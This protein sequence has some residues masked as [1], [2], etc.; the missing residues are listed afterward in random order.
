MLWIDPDYR[1]VFPTDRIIDEMSSIEGEVYRKGEGRVTLRFE[2]NGEHFFLKRHSGI[3]WR[4]IFKDLL[5]GRLPILG[6]INEW[7]ALER[8][9][10][11]NISTLRP[12]AFAQRGANP[13]TRKSFL[14]TRELVNTISLED[15]VREWQKRPDFIRIKRK[16]IRQVARVAR[17]FHNNGMNHRDF[18]ICHL[19]VARAWLDQPQGD[20][21][22]FVIDLHRAQIRAAVP[23]RWLVKDIG[24]L[25]FSVMEAGLTRND[26]FRFVREYT[27]NDLRKVLKQDAGFWREVK[28]RADR[29]YATRPV[30]TEAGGQ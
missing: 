18:Y 7:H 16:I 23:R 22:I 9:Q 29:L 8:L 30:S 12:V 17:R 2:R 1:K 13:A 4:E 28:N 10:I 25:Y 24:S 15:V 20:P 3:G 11:L 21:E 5:Q 14:L 6:A 26:Y 27:G 19:H